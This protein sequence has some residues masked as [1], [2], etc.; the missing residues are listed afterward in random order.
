MPSRYPLHIEPV[1]VPKTM[2]RTFRVEARDEGGEW[3]L[4]A[5]E[6][7]NYQRLVRMEVNIETSD[8]RFVPEA[9]WGAER[10]HVFAW[11]VDG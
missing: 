5:R 2:T 10:V 11:D 1:G 8:I 4:V 9:T 3:Q 6:E 7:S